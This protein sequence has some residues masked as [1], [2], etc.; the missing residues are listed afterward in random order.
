M[1]FA[2]STNADSTLAGGPSQVFVSRLN[3]STGA[4]HK[5]PSAITHWL[6]KFYAAAMAITSVAMLVF[7]TGPQLV[8]QP[9]AVPLRQL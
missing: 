6:W 9:S 7:V 5:R 2:T 8:R 1:L 4:T 3:S